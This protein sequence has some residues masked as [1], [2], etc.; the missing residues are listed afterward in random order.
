MGFFF[1]FSSSTENGDFHKG[2]L[3]Y[4]ISGRQR[5]LAKHQRFLLGYS[6]LRTW[7]LR[8]RL[9]SCGSHWWHS[10][11]ANIGQAKLGTQGKTGQGQAKLGGVWAE[12]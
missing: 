3:D 11:V 8:T 2:E 7:A 6:P 12:E 5:L 4:G 1:F 9:A 10:G